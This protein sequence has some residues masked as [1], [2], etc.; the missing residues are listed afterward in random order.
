MMTMRQLKPSVQVCIKDLVRTCLTVAWPR[1]TLILEETQCKLKILTN[2]RKI[3][4]PLRS[5]S[6]RVALQMDL[7]LEMVTVYQLRSRQ[8]ATPTLKKPNINASVTLGLL[9]MA[10]QYLLS[11]RNKC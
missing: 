5:S 3:K 2:N 9:V 4:L 6:Q 10:V 7:V 11:N 1:K 8:K